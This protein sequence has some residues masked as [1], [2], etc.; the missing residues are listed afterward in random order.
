[1][2][3]ADVSSEIIVNPDAL[4]LKLLHKKVVYHLFDKMVEGHRVREEYN[5]NL[6]C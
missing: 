6:E 2:A 5:N 3:E 1:M 4:V